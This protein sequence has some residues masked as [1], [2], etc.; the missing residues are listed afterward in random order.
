MST[1]IP[2]PPAQKPLSR[3]QKNKNMQ[4]KPVS[5]IPM[6]HYAPPVPAK[7]PI[8]IKTIQQDKVLNISADLWNEYL[9][10]DIRFHIH[11]IQNI[12]YTQ[13][14]KLSESVKIK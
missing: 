13:L 9:K 4:V 10:I 1:R 3:V 6:S 8:V 14:Y 2:K 7:K 11:A 5:D 12:L